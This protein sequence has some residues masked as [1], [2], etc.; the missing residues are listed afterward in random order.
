[1]VPASNPCLEASSYNRYTAKLELAPPPGGVLFGV[2]SW[3]D[4]F[5]HLLEEENE[6]LYTVAENDCSNQKFTVLIR[7]HEAT[8]LGS[9]DRHNETI[10]EVTVSTEFEDIGFQSYIGPIKFIILKYP[11]ICVAAYANVPVVVLLH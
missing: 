1:M 7:G 10:D 5:R 8:F 6:S 4:S 3:V 11:F 2:V 9:G